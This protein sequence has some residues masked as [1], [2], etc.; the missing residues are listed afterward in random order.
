VQYDPTNK[1]FICPCHGSEFNGHTGSVE[2]GPAQQGLTRL[3]I[4][5]GTDGQLYVV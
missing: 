5:E 4:A 3:R 2:V 1:V